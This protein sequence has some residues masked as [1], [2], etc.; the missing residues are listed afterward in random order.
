[1][2]YSLIKCDIRLQQLCKLYLELKEEAFNII[3]DLSLFRD[4]SQ[5]GLMR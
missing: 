3:L 4:K 2:S 1:M 5:K